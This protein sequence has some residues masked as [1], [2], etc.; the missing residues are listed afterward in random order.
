M[1]SGIPSFFKTPKHRSFD[2]KPLFYDEEKE[3]K[4]EL[5]QLAEEYR[6]G[7]LSDERRVERLRGSLSQRWTAGNRTGR[8]SANFAQSLRFLMV[9]AVLGGLVWFFFNW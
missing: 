2:Y 4:R 5:E 3:R 8:R 9:L 6:S 1:S 7:E